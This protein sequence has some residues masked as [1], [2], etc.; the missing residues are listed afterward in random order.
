MLYGRYMAVSFLVARHLVITEEESVRR[1]NAYR[2]DLSK[3]TKP[4][5]GN[6]FF[7]Y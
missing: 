1:C 4:S 5:R 6:R 7:M 2:A 3:K